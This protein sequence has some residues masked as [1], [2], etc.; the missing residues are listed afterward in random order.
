MDAGPSTRANTHPAAADPRQPA[1]P[2]AP[3]TRTR[4]PSGGPLQN[5]TAA[6]GQPAMVAGSDRSL[7][8]RPHPSA[9]RPCDATVTGHPSTGAR[10][11]RHAG[12]L[13]TTSLH[14]PGPLRKRRTVN[15]PTAPA[16]YNCLCS[17]SRPPAGG[18]HVRWRTPRGCDR[19]VRR[20]ADGGPLPQSSGRL[21]RD[22]AAACGGHHGPTGR[23]PRACRGHYGRPRTCCG[24]S[25]RALWKQ[26]GPLGCAGERSGPLCGC[27]VGVC[28]T[29]QSIVTFHRT[30]FLLPSRLPMIS[31]RF[32]N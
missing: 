14:S 15:P 30:H 18:R 29:A 7:R 27:S 31:W 12:P 2:P 10:N 13:R 6:V 1:R 23:P 26:R 19:S 24:S 8:G 11:Y 25:D 5:R 21:H 9:R 4:Q 16:C 28:P 22:T 3:A 32:T 20:H 17:S